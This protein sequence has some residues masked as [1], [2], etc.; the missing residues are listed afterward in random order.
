ML[1]NIHGLIDCTTLYAIL[2][3]HLAQTGLGD[4]GKSKVT[5]ETDEEA[6]V[7]EMFNYSSNYTPASIFTL[8]LF[9][10]PL[11]APLAAYFRPSTAGSH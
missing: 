6:A 3:H 4:Y 10:F 1:I 8:F 9:E 11:L 5:W 7:K 2:E